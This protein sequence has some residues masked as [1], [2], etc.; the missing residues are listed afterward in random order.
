MTTIHRSIISGRLLDRWLRIQLELFTPNLAPER[1]Q[2]I[3]S[4]LARIMARHDEVSPWFNKKAA[5]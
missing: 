2:R 4:I 5:R 3:K 1:R